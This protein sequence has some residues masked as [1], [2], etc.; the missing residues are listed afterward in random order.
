MSSRRSA[1]A[2]QAL[3]YSL[4]L[5]LSQRRWRPPARRCPFWLRWQASAPSFPVAIRACNSFRRVPRG[6]RPRAPPAWAS[7]RQRAASSPFVAFSRRGGWGCAG[8][9]SWQQP[10]SNSAMPSNHVRVSCLFFGARARRQG[11]LAAARGL[12]KITHRWRVARAGDSSG[13]HGLRRTVACRE[14]GRAG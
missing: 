14:W 5:I 6:R 2:R 11:W 7:L 3:F 4:F 13:C 9:G 1:E 12:G 10:A 8:W